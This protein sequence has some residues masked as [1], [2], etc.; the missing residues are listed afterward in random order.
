MREDVPA[1]AGVDQGDVDLVGAVVVAGAGVRAFDERVDPH[2]DV[3]GAAGRPGL[4]GA[5]GG[6]RRAERVDGGLDLGGRERRQAWCRGGGT[7]DA[8]SPGGLLLGVGGAVAS[9]RLKHARQMDV[10]VLDLV[11]A[12]AKWSGKDFSEAADSFPD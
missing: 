8:G 9:G 10:K 4:R 6:E 3:L 11:S 5:H 12:F 7:C 1:G 2:G